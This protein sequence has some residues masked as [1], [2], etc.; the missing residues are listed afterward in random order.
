M[1]SH[2]ASLTGVAV[3]LISFHALAREPTAGFT[4]RSSVDAFMPPSIHTLPTSSTACAAPGARDDFVLIAL[5]ESTDPFRTMADE[6]VPTQMSDNQIVGSFPASRYGDLWERL[7]AGFA[8][9][10]RKGPLVSRYE[11]WYR[12]HPAH[13]R[14]TIQRG[15][16]FL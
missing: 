8:L 1:R 9:S 4:G 7:R 16:R 2:R 5:P 15:R 14:R 10:D 11:A 12:K 6:L 3:V 13:L